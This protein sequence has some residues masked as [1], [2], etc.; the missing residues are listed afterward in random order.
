MI[1]EANQVALQ[2]AG[3]SFILGARIPHL[4]G[5][6]REWRDKRPDEVIPDGLV[7]TQPW[8]STSS[9]KARG[10]PDRV[11]HYQYRHDGAR[12]TLRG[13]D[14][15]VA[16]AERAVD[17]NAPVKRN[18]FIKLT[19]A[20]KSV[21][22]DLEI[23]ARALAGWK[24]YTTNLVGQSPEFVIDAYH[25]LWRIERSFRMSKH[26]LQARPIYHHK[27]ESIDAHLTIVFAALAVSH[28][29]ET[30]NRL[31]HREIRAHH[32]PLPHGANQGRQ[33]DPR[34]RR[35]ST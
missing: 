14:E 18:R 8:P 22:R 33:T 15:Q 31:E 12:R 9:E 23:K 13:I 16:K 5:V 10:I 25:Q 20:T 17:G 19:G 7:L 30:P 1:S 26:D 28:W 3:L 32:T 21:N 27:R 35:P 34:R 6:V 2:A 24:G 4:P 29:I 11:I